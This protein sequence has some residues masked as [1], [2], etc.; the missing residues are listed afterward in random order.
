VEERKGGRVEALLVM[1]I[2]LEKP[3]FE[4]KTRF[5]RGAEIR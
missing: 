4:E 2:L 3:S 5:L 1:T